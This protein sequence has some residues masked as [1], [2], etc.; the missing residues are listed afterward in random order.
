MQQVNFL[1]ALPKPTAVAFPARYILWVGLAFVVLL[2]FISLLLLWESSHYRSK[3]ATLSQQKVQIQLTNQQ[4][5]KSNPQAFAESKLAE[6]VKALEKIVAHKERVYGK[7]N[8]LS[9]ASGFSAYLA[10]LAR[11]TPQG[12]WFR[13]I[14]IDNDHQ[15]ILLKG[16]ALN[17]DKLPEFMSAIAKNA[18]FAKTQFH[19]FSINED[20]AHPWISFKLANKNDNNKT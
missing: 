17:S 13:Q 4:I 14:F 2:A 7:I 1:H 16:Y 18:I 15:Q 6:N 5:Q 11:S 20:Q 8:K 9:K 19:A 10:A 3:L 12:M